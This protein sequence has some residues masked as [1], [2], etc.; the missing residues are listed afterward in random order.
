MFL[1]PGG[2]YTVVLS[3]FRGDEEMS[4]DPDRHTIL[5]LKLLSSHDTNS[6]STRLTISVRVLLLVSL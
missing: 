3:V 5:Y 6:F 2:T 4:T 1:I